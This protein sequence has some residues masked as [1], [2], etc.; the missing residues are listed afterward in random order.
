MPKA[1]RTL[2]RGPYSMAEHTARGFNILRSTQA[3]R[4]GRLP[5]NQRRK[6]RGDR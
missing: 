5:G 6:K 4:T 2:L 1:K 3:K